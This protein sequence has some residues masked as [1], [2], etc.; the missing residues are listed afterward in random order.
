MKKKSNLYK[1]Y[2]KESSP[3]LKKLLLDKYK[4]YKTN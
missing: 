2:I 1:K 4:I 3:G